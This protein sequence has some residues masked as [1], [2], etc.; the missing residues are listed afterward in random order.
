MNLKKLNETRNKL[1]QK[2]NKSDSFFKEFGLLDDKVYSEGA[3]PKKYKELTGLSISIFSKCEEC[4]AYHLQNCKEQGC[5]KE[6]VVES[7]KIAVVGGGSVTYPWARKAIQI[8]NDLE[9]ND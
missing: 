4:I 9:F 8:T 2:L 1:N 5:T 3:I 6:E 7:I